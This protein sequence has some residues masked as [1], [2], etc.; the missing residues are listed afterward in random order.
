ATLTSTF[1]AIANRTKWTTWW[2][3]G[4]SKA[5]ADSVQVSLYTNISNNYTLRSTVS[6]TPSGPT[7]SCWSLSV[8]LTEAEILAQNTATIMDRVLIIKIRCDN[9][10]TPCDLMYSSGYS[11]DRLGE[12]LAMAGG[13]GTGAGPTGTAAPGP[14]GSPSPAPPSPGGQAFPLEAIAGIAAGCLL[15]SAALPFLIIFCMRRRPTTQ[16]RPASTRG[17]VHPEPEMIIV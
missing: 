7:G 4:A 17:A 1:G 15:V 16:H 9:V 13:T 14:P 3:L 6:V 5:M 12:Q 10:G 8:N 2:S 11:W